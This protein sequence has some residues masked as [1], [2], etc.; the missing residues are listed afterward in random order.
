MIPY[1]WDR[2]LGGGNGPLV[3]TYFLDGTED[4]DYYY[5]YTSAN[6]MFYVDEN[7][8]EGVGITPDDGYDVA[9]IEDIV[10]DSGISTID[11]EDEDSDG[12]IESWGD[13]LLLEQAV[14]YGVDWTIL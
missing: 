5:V 12:N 8:Y 7:T 13:D 3:S 2:E 1:W 6:A 10:D 11:Y 4:N 14:L 9:D